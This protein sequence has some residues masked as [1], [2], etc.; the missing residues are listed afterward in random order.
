MFNAQ[1]ADG[2]NVVYVDFPLDHVW[3]IREKVWLARQRGEKAIGWMYFVHLTTGEHFFLHLLLTII[4]GTTFFE[5]LRTVDD[6]EHPTFQAACETLGLLHDNV[7]W[8][9]CMRE[10]CIDEDAKRLRNLFFALLRYVAWY[11]ASTHHE[12]RH[13]WGCLQQ[14]PTTPW[15]Q[16]SVDKQRLARLFGNVARIVACRN[17]TCQSLIGYGAW[18]W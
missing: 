3:K 8:D 9:T 7:E 15:G 14:H 2:Q 5:H 11:V 4:P 6:T 1:N 13:Y 12:W 10:A 18:L 17:A 16:I